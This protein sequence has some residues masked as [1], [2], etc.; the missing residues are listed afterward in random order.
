MRKGATRLVPAS[1]VSFYVVFFF[2]FCEK[3]VVGVLGVMWEEHD[4]VGPGQYR[5]LLCFLCV[6]C[7]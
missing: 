7:V 4:E 3:H 5:Q 2:V 1:T 6:C